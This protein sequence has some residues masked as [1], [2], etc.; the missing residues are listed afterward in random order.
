MAKKITKK[1]KMSKIISENPDAVEI[2]FNSGLSCVGCP[3]AQQETL[4]EGC[5][6]HGMNDKDIDELLK[7]VNKNSR[8]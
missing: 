1:Q 8:S 6:A 7:K 5:K 2:L 4:E 3:M